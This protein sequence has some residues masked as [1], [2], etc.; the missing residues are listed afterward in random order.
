[1]A[2][3]F[4]ERSV[5]LDCDKKITGI[6]MDVK[7]EVSVYVKLIQEVSLNFTGLRYKVINS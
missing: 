4:V 5:A 2:F 1:M 6:P 7:Q 3:T